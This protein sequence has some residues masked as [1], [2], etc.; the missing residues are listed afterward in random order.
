MGILVS[1]PVKD[2]QFMHSTCITKLSRLCSS[3]GCH[4]LKNLH[5]KISESAWTT[6]ADNGHRGSCFYSS[7]GPVDSLR[8]C[9]F[10]VFKYS[11]NSSLLSALWF[12][13]KLF[14][15]YT[16]PHYF[17]MWLICLARKPFP[18]LPKEKFGERSV[19]FNCRWHFVRGV[20]SY[21]HPLWRGW[22]ELPCLRSKYYLPP[23]TCILHG[24]RFL[25][26]YQL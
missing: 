10:S 3:E 21:F 18:S 23:N 14:V 24:S 2:L 9:Y 16:W 5:F 8:N 7:R 4:L 26:P 19:A 20:L 22:P 25:L 15:C 11:I 12:V 6:G 13:I 1:S 17:V